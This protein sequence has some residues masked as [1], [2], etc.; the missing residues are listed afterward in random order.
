VQQARAVFT[1]YFAKI[2]MDKLIF[3]DESGVHLSMTRAYGRAS[4]QERV[5]DYAPFNKGTRVTMIAAIGSDEVKAAMFGDWHVDGEIFLHF[6]R[7]CLVPTLEPGHRVILDN[8]STHKVSGVREAVEA[9]GAKLVY[10]PPYSP[11]L[12]PIELFWSKI[13][14]YLRKKAARTFDDLKKTI[15][16]AF[17]EIKQSDFH[18]WFEHCGYCNQ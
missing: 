11:D 7:E 6:I 13:K 16:Y 2:D 18:N 17:K 10:L 4:S 15:G 12:T 14:S 1:E 5:I 9:T 8:L 3:I